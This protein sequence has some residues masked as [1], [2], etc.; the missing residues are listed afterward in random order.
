MEHEH[1][2]GGCRLTYQYGKLGPLHARW[3]RALKARLH[4]MEA[5]LDP[6]FVLQHEGQ[7]LCYTTCQV[8]SSSK[9]QV[10]GR[11]CL[12]INPASTFSKKIQW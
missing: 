3:A 11:C 2:K 10:Q 1:A 4:A 12:V 6:D 8:S 5:C 9:L 7:K